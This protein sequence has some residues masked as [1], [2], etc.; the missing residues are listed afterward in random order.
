[1][2]NNPE[3]SPGPERQDWYADLPAELVGR[4]ALRYPEAYGYTPEEAAWQRVHPAVNLDMDTIT[5]ALTG[6]GVVV[7]LATGISERHNARKAA[8]QADLHTSIRNSL[9]GETR[10][11]E[12]PILHDILSKKQEQHYD[13]I[14]RHTVVLLRARD[15][16][17]TD[18]MY[19]A[20]YAEIGTIFARC[21][22]L[23]R[24]KLG[25]DKFAKPNLSKAEKVT[26]DALR[27]FSFDASHVELRG[28]NLEHADLSLLLLEGAQFG[29]LDIEDL[30]GLKDDDPRTV[31][32]LNNDED[33]RRTK[34]YH[35]NF[36][37]ADL[38]GASFRYAYAS[39]SKYRGARVRDVDFTGAKINQADFTY[40]NL[41]FT[42]LRKAHK[43]NGLILDNVT[44]MM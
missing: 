41:E 18:K 16:T 39:D 1:M 27:R 31:K 8:S 24:K 40:A 2:S 14:F 3:Q 44:N 11:A 4:I 6:L 33:P 38:N 28:F 5:Q 20:F 10:L 12:I 22:P 7:T 15:V 26:L 35:T 23:L 13:T 19:R 25:L 37:Y 30:L 9:H 34:V 42:D 32:F 29:P 43:A 36:S 21:A 17:N